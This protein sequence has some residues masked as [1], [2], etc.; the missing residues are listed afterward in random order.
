MLPVIADVYKIRIDTSATQTAADVDFKEI[1][2]RTFN[3][4]I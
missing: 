4:V 2:V 3:T 1:H